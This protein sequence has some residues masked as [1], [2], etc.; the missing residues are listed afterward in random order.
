[1][2]VDVHGAR[3]EREEE[4]VSGLAPAV[5]ELRVSLAHRVRHDAVAYIAAIDEEILRICPCLRRLWRTR[6]AGERHAAGARLDGDARLGY[7]AAE[8]RRG[9]LGERLRTQ[10]PA[11]ATVVAQREADC[12][13]GE[14]D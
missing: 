14:R 2:H 7:V 11:G 1:M 5:Q 6:E 13:V 10:V 4:H 3:I 8:Q 9:A 12:G